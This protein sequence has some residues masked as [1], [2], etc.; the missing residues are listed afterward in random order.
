MEFLNIYKNG[1]APEILDDK[2]YPA[3][4]WELNKGVCIFEEKGEMQKP[5][6]SDYLEQDFDTL[7]DADK[8]RFIKLQ[9]RKKIKD[10]NAKLRK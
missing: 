5:L 7:S 4:M 10:N 8:K 1:K 6:L 9:R 2:E 3:W